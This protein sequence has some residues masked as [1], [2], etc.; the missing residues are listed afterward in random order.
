M[1]A[2]RDH[3]P[4]VATTKEVRIGVHVLGEPAFGGVFQYELATLE[5]LLDKSPDLSPR[6]SFAL[7][8][9]RGD[10]LP[11][12]RLRSC[13]WS[14]HA[15]PSRSMHKALR[16]ASH[17]GASDRPLARL[18]KQ[19]L[20]P[21]HQRH[22]TRSTAAR[23]SKA[24]SSGGSSVDAVS[25]SCSAR[26]QRPSASKRAFLSSWRF[27]D[28][29]HRLQPEFPEVSA[30]GQWEKR[31]YLFRNA[32]RG[33]TLLIADSEVGKEDIVNCY[34]EYGVSPEKVSPSYP[35]SLHRISTRSRPPSQSS[36][37]R[38]TG[39]P[40]LLLPCAVLA[41]QESRSRRGSDRHAQAGA[42][43][44]DSHSLHRDSS[45]RSHERNSAYDC[46]AGR[47][48]RLL[49]PDPPSGVPRLTGGLRPLRDRPGPRD[50]DLL[51]PDEHPDPRSLDARCPVLTSG[52]P[53]RTRA[54][55]GRRT[56]GRS[57]GR[58][59]YATG[60][61]RLA[62]D[63]ILRDDLTQRGVARLALYTREDFARRLT[64]ILDTA[65]ELILARRANGELQE[66]N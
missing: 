64:E 27:T 41:S 26:R 59:R 4:G 58:A 3:R 43:A 34:G 61:Q 14:I 20:P 8:Y 28:L 36:S 32:T 7:F 48:L 50:A 51:R 57:N 63:E 16:L 35:S 46:G 66:A 49:S 18:E 55:R 47:E 65:S 60:M 31:E 54:G 33:A 5:A 24:P 2:L 12:Q 30:D 37:A 17:A 15:F 11:L 62:T 9:E 21:R 10:N 29:Q 44:R 6:F 53:R 39:C 52:H 38:R 13:G 19:P 45:P 22:S 56:P 42:R 23:V 40:S 1:S 25:T